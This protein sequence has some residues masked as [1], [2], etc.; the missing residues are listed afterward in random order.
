MDNYRWIVAFIFVPLFI[1]NGQTGR[2]NAE[3]STEQ[4]LDAASKWVFPADGLISDVF[5]SR[6]GRHKGLDIAGPAESPVYSVEEG[7][8]IKSY[9]SKTYGHVIFIEHP[10]GFQT[11]YAHLS[12]RLAAK[13]T[14]V[15]KGEL[16]GR[17]GSTGHSYGSHLH[18]EA[19]CGKWTLEKENAFDPL[20]AFGGGGIGDKVVALETAATKAVETVALEK[21]RSEEGRVYTVQKGDTIWGIARKFN[22]SSKDIKKLNQLGSSNLIITGQKLIVRN[23]S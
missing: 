17:M 13:G 22:M 14:M 12:K 5:S 11:V 6:G 16:I 23:E 18:F 4:I 10:S 2:I 19:H 9:H 3:S 20:L 8:V 1:V 15:S 21:I 7:R